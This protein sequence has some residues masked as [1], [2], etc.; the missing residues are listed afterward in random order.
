MV[1]YVIVILNLLNFAI[2]SRFFVYVYFYLSKDL[3]FG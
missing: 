2:Y 1:F 3:K